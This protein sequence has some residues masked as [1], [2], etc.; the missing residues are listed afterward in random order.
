[1]S[2]KSVSIVYI[3]VFIPQV[4]D[5]LDSIVCLLYVYTYV[6]VYMCRNAKWQ[7][8]PQDF[9][10]VC[11]GIT[12]REGCG[13]WGGAIREGFPVEAMSHSSMVLLGR[14]RLYK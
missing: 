3:H 8:F 1:M 4:E 11:T 6:Y 14:G 13:E 10:E 7:M 2:S 9:R 12:G 5:V